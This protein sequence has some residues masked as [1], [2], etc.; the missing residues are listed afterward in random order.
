M[1]GYTQSMHRVEYGRILFGLFLITLAY[2]MMIDPAFAA[3]PGAGFGCIGGHAVGTLYDTSMGC[4]S[5]MNMNNVFTFLVCNMERLASN[6]LGEMYCGIISDL[7][8]AVMG[9][10]TLA[11]VIFGVGFTIGVIPATARDFQMFLLKMAVITVFAT[12]ADAMI[13]T[14]YALLIT[15]L[16]EGTAIGISTMF[17][18]DLAARTGAVTGVDVYRYLDSF[19][20]QTMHFATDYVGAKWEAGQNPCKNAVFAVL[21]IM[22]VAFPPVFFIGVMIIFRVAVTFLRAIFGYL[23]SIIGIVFLLTLSPF[24]LSFYLF[25]QTR[26]FFDKWLGY[27]V[28][29][30]L[31]MVI[32]FAFLGFIL[33][34][35]VT[36]ISG[37][38]TNIIMPV[39]E[40]FT[41]TTMR[42]PWQ[43]CTICEFNVLD[44]E[45]NPIPDDQ[46][47]DTIQQ[48]RLAC[49]DNPPKPIR[50]MG[51]MAPPNEAT[52]GDTDEKKVQTALMKF[53]LTGL[54]S[55][56]VLAYVVE[57]L[58]NYVGALAQ[59][60]AGGMGATYAPQLGGGTAIGAKT[61]MDMPGGEML[62]T[63]EKGVTRGFTNEGVLKTTFVPAAAGITEGIKWMIQGGPRNEDG[64]TNDPGLVDSFSNFILNPHRDS[65]H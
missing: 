57:F 3:K 27:L 65:G 20:G 52:G 33:S 1:M 36:H 60:L 28:T 45:G 18:D 35:N 48:G 58:L 26:P 34:I 10:L 55:L 11:T 53:A 8:P 59:V 4:P 22:A 12:Q 43:Y 6:L 5:T 13:G 38:L 19:L 49:K 44:A 56:L 2:F 23:Y 25:K 39:Q 51:A 41:S 31:Q 32:L 7:V 50:A 14:G 47:G 64:L 29:F 30:S 61:S 54:L 42:A 37:S 9:M 17:P 16:R 24:F 21:A 15:G 63:F 46:Y 62:E 40:N